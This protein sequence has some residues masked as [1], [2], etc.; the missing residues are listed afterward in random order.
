MKYKIISYHHSLPRHP[1]IKST[2]QN[3]RNIVLE[4]LS[5]VQRSLFLSSKFPEISTFAHGDVHSELPLLL[6]N[7]FQIRLI[8]RRG[9]WIGENK[10]LIMVGDY[11]DRGEYPWETYLYL[12][13]LREEAYSFGG[14]VVL[15]AGNHELMFL[16][17][18]NPKIFFDLL[19]HDIR[20][21]RLQAAYYLENILF[22]HAGLH[23]FHQRQIERDQDI[24]SED[25]ELSPSKLV[26]YINDLFRK[27]ILDGTAY[28]QDAHSIFCLPKTKG[29]LSPIGGIFWL[30]GHDLFEADDESPL[31]QVHGHSVTKTGI[32]ESEL[33][34]IFNIDA[35]L[36]KSF[37]HHQAVLG[38]SS[39]GRF[40]DFFKKEDWDVMSLHRTKS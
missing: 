40:F 36:S 19:M 4:S 9:H 33:G 1:L 31:F 18:K 25:A 23:P 22:T 35:G 24:S 2:V 17:Y 13:Q 16:R 32:R 8:D 7:L 6:E 15:L 10:S 26:H 39:S 12:R 27:E 28:T 34:R 3:M 21:Q 20:S 38:I 29:G 5:S 30:D 37:G 11:I 14:K